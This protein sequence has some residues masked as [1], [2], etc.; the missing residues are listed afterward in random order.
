MHF[1]LSGEI[2]AEIADQYRVVRKVVET[3]LNEAL[4][5]E[6]YGDAIQ[7]IAVIPIILGPRFLSGREER[8]LIKHRER[9]ADYRLFIDL[10]RF[11]DGSPQDQTNLLVQNVLACVEDIARKLKGKLDGER[12]RN[13]IQSLFPELAAHP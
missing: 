10:A 8:R 13:D 5:N 6:S 11:K 3:R 12:L 9:V 4:T 1:F 2:D 7:E